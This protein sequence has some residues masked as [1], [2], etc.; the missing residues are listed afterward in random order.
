MNTEIAAFQAEVRG[1][2]GTRRKG[3]APYGAEMIARGRALAMRLQEGGEPAVAVARLLGIARKTLMKWLGEPA[4]R[5]A[6]S[7]AAAGFVRVGLQAARGEEA[8]AATAG[9]R[10]V[11][12]RGYRIEGLD[13]ATAVAILRE[14]G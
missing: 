1:R 3:A 13:Q 6:R 7:K 4:R 9:V 11:S 2:R 14:V 8:V 12:P 10:L 5:T